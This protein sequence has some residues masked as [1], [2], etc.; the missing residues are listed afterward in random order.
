M[1]T[2]NNSPGKPGSPTSMLIEIASSP[3]SS[4]TNKSIPSPVKFADLNLRKQRQSTTTTTT[5]D[6]IQST[7]TSFSANS[8]TTTSSK[9]AAALLRRRKKK[10]N[11]TQDDDYE[12]KRYVTDPNKIGNIGG[13]LRMLND[14]YVKNVEFFFF[15]VNRRGAD[16][17][18][19]FHCI[20]SWKFRLPRCTIFISCSSLLTCSFSSLIFF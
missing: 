13:K 18:T 2:V 3:E 11:C 19:L 7:T 5:N 9:S 6:T 15:W 12:L 17:Q 8:T 14:R 4:P 1:T 10:K 16:R 20:F